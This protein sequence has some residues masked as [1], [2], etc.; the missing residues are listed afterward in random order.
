MPKRSKAKH[1]LDEILADSFELPDSR[2]ELVKIYRQVAKAADTRLDRLEDYALE[3]NYK[4]ALQWSYARAQRYI[5]EWSGPEAT[6]FNTKPPESDQQLRQKIADIEDFLRKPSSTKEGIRSIHKQRA[7]TLNKNFGTNF[8][9]NEVATFFDSELKSHM[10]DKIA[11]SDTLVEVIGYIQKHKKQ[12]I[13]AVETANA[14]DLKVPDNMVGKLVQMTI[15]DLG[16][17]VVDYLQSKK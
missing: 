11:G 8:T 12:V 13:K 10:H 14:K 2:T 1:S 7:A 16:D 3:D 6:R 5:K 9:W 15:N 4:N 17:E